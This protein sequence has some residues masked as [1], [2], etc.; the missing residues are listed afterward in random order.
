MPTIKCPQVSHYRQYPPGTEYVYSYFK[1]RWKI[2][3]Y[4]LLWLAVFHQAPA[5]VVLLNRSFRGQ[6]D[7]TTTWARAF[8]RGGVAAYTHEARRQLRSRSRPCPRAPSSQR[9]CSSPWS[10]RPCLL[11]ADQL[12]GDAARRGLVPDD[13]LHAVARAKEDHP[14]SFPPHRVRPCPGSLSQ[15]PRLGYRGVSSV[16]SASVR[17]SSTFG[18]LTMA[19]LSASS[20]FTAARSF[21]CQPT[22]RSTSPSRALHLA[23]EHSTITSG[24]RGRAQGLEHARPPRG[25][26]RG[27]VGLTTSPSVLNLWGK[28]LKEKIKNRKGTL[29][30]FRPGRPAG[31]RAAAP[32]PARRGLRGGRR[33]STGHNC[34]RRTSG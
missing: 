9:T 23:A 20:T 27:R 11:L 28:E 22:P 21:R 17:T 25:P 8:Q 10:T 6:G 18:G 33:R 30:A 13:G 19:S 31:H 4:M 16:E 3:R 29:V 7:S 24:A 1:A 26:R 32:R 12:P 5:G 14:P 2:R 34:C 15:A